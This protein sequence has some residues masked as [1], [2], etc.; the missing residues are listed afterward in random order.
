LEKITDPSLKKLAK[1]DIDNLLKIV[2]ESSKEKTKAGDGDKKN[3]QYSFKVFTEEF[4]PKF[5]IPEN[6]KLNNENI[7][8]KLTSEN[9]NNDSTK[10]DLEQDPSNATA[11]PEH[12]NVIPVV[13]ENS[14]KLDYPHPQ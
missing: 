1:S 9:I 13:N 2:H 14:V 4:F 5:I 7:Q 10:Q 6:K 12:E 11:Q 3:N 8:E